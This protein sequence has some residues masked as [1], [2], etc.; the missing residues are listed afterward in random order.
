MQCFFSLKQ[1]TAKNNASSAVL[2]GIWS[3][4][5]VHIRQEAKLTDQSVQMILLK[6]PVGW[7]RWV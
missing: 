5:V 7:K 2:K 1:Q 4:V 6:N 3:A